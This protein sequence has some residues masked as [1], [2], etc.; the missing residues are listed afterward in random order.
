MTRMEEGKGTIRKTD[1]ENRI[2]ALSY[3]PFF[4]GISGSTI[5]SFCPPRP[6][7]IPSHHWYLF[8][9]K[10]SNQGHQK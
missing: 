8:Q 1:R 2:D 7:S 6:P 10:D 5:S 3:I 9:N 4:L